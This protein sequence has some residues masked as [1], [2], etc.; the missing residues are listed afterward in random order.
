MNKT[1][2][3]GLREALALANARPTAHAFSVAAEIN[4]LIET[5]TARLLEVQQRRVSRG[6][7]PRYGRE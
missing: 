3:D 7:G 1:Y 2:L 6:L 4:M 5:E